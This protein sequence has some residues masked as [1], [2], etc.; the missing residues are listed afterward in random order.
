MTDITTIG[1]VLIDLIQSGWT[2]QGIPR[3]DA[4]PGGAPANLAVAASR[5]GAKTAFIA[6]VAT[7]LSSFLENQPATSR[8]R[9][10]MQRCQA[11]PWKT[12]ATA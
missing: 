11:A 12:S 1:E 7:A 3:F 8:S 9:C 4:N 10:T 5:L 2:E 6:A